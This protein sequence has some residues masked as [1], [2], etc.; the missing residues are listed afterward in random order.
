MRRLQRPPDR[1]RIKGARHSPQQRPGPMQRRPQPHQA[2]VGI[3]PPPA[4]AAAT[5]AAAHAT[6]APPGPGAAA[7]AAAASGVGALRRT[8][9]SWRRRGPS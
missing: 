9:R 5:A 7:A 6:T 2:A 4:A 1:P 3:Q 8:E